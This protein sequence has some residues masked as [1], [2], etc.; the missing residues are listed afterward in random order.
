M[1]YHWWKYQSNRLLPH[2]TPFINILVKKTQ[3]KD[4]TG[5]FDD[6]ENPGLSKTSEISY[7]ERK[8]LNSYS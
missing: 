8:Y 5:F 2:E 6:T 4:K 7:A 1:L 3:K